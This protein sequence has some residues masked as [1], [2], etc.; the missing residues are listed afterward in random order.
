M[1]TF[2]DL[3]EGPVSV[4]ATV[5]TDPGIDVGGRDELR[6]FSG[7]AN[8]VIQLGDPEMVVVTIASAGS[9][10]GRFL[11]ADRTTPVPTPSAPP[12]LVEAQPLGAGEVLIWLDA[13]TPLYM[14]F[15]A[16]PASRGGVP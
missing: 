6:G 7:T 4:T 14:T 9:V 3:T 10:R 15:E 8:G 2:E 5:P 12:P 11:K 1:A 16:P 13:E